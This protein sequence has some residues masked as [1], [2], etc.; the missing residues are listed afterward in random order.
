MAPCA[1]VP[2]FFPS[3]EQVILIIDDDDRVDCFRQSE[4]FSNCRSFP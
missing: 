3:L 1:F 2:Q 4:R